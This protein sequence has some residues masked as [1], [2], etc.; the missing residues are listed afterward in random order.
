MEDAETRQ[1]EWVVV[2]SEGAARGRGR[3][4]F[5]KVRG[6]A[7]GKKEEQVALWEGGLAEAVLP[8]LRRALGATLA[9]GLRDLREHV[10]GLETRRGTEGWNC[11]QHAVAQE[12][13]AV[14]LE[15]ARHAREAM[16]A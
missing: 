2:V 7:R 13:L 12:G 15:R 3:S 10:R 11:A 6:E 5:E 8:A 14:V 16:A 1:L 4:V 9:R